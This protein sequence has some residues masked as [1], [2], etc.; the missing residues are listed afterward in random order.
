[1]ADQENDGSV[2]GWLA[3]FG[4]GLHAVSSRPLPTAASARVEA[5]HT[6]RALRRFVEI[7][8]GAGHPTLLDLGPLCGSNVTFFGEQLGC[9]LVVSDLFAELDRCVRE[10]GAQALSQ[11][12]TATIDQPAESLDGVLCWDA[13][14]YLPDDAAAS[15]SRALVRVLKPGG[16]ALAFFSTMSVDATEFTRFVIDGPDRIRYRPFPSSLG[17]QRVWLSRDTVRLFS[18]LQ[19]DETF[20]QSHGVREVLLRKRVVR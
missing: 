17:Q 13:C 9:R 2:A 12:V 4:L 8:R 16:V 10:R 7:V 5:V 15:L 3:R 18:P 14:D 19:A 1:V 11:T 20:L 6:T